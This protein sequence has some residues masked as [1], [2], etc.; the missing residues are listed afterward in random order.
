M[1]SYHP[2]AQRTS[3][4]HN[5]GS[6]SPLCPQGLGLTMQVPNTQ[7]PES[8]NS[9][10]GLC[11]VPKAWHSCFSSVS[12]VSSLLS[13]HPGWPSLGQMTHLYTL[14]Q[15]SWPDWSFLL[16]VEP[17]GIINIFFKC[18]SEKGF[19]DGQDRKNAERDQLGIIRG[20]DSRCQKCPT[21]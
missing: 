21:L 4:S 13:V 1:N 11:V 19:P 9:S 3:I 2:E 6:Q 10:S 17:C 5:L 16:W 8:L 18:I 12:L 15:P 20:A 14:Q 7:E